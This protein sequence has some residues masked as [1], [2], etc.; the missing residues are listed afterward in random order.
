MLQ[1]TFKDPLVELLWKQICEREFGEEM[2]KEENQTWKE[3][4][5]D[6]DS[7]MG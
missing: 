3:M 5:K 6:R 2:E 4:V 7:E 1:K